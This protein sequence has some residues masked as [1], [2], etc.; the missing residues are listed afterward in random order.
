MINRENA[1]NRLFTDRSNALDVIDNIYDSVGSC[2]E[3]AYAWEGEYT[4]Y[5]FCSF[6]DDATFKK[7]FYCSK[8]EK[9]E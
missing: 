7:D 8:Y 4:K 2:K 5:I 1:K 6:F 9:G 3:C